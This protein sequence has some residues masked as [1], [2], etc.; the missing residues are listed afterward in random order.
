MTQALRSAA[1]DFR[2]PMRRPSLRRVAQWGA[3]LALVS[4][5]SGCF[6]LAAGGLVA[7]TYAAT[8]RRSI[9]AQAD[10]K[11]IGTKGV[12]RINEA[13][14]DRVHVDVV[15]FNRKVLLVGEV[16][17]DAVKNQI[18]QMIGSIENVTGVVNELAVTDFN[19]SVSTRASDA[20]ITAEVKARLVNEKDVMANAFKVVTE[21]GVVYLMGRVT[22]REGDWAANEA[23]Q[24]SGVLQVVK[25]FDY[26]TEDELKAMTTRAAPE[27]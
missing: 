4:T 12:S 9:G 22:E 2:A 10:D 23:R 25:V 17:S 15:A 14:G 8:D 3:A 16:P 11:V 24:V 5:L 26:I 18:G 27:Q 21:R 20:A 13:F 7:G 6:V 1:R 19:S